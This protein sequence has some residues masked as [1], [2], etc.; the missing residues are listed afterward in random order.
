MGRQETPVPSRVVRVRPHQYE[1]EGLRRG[2][3]S[4]FVEGLEV[5]LVPEHGDDRV[6]VPAKFFLVGCCKPCA[7]DDL[8]HVG[9]MRG[10][11]R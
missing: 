4:A 1:K 11:E 9:V 3:A 7:R 2:K 6:E 5:S 10:V 8:A